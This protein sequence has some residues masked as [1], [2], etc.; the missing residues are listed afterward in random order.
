MCVRQRFRSTLMNRIKI[1]SQ[2]ISGR[3]LNL[4]LYITPDMK[5]TRILII[6]IFSCLTFSGCSSEQESDDSKEHK[7]ELKELLGQLDRIVEK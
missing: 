4:T 1:I 5:P 6:L 2:V 3:L 7:R